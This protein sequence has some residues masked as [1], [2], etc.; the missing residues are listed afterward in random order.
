MILRRIVLSGQGV[1]R[2]QVGLC[3]DSRKSRMGKKSCDKGREC[4][5]ARHR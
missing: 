2:L 4:E 3:L 5:L 1:P